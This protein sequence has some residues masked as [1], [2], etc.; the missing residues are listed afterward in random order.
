MDRRK[1]I[2]TNSIACLGLYLSI[3]ELKASTHFINSLSNIELN[4]LFANIN[5][6]ENRKLALLENSIYKYNNLSN[7]QILDS[8]K[9][10]Y[11]LRYGERSNNK[12]KRST[13]KSI[14][15]N[16][17]LNIN[18][19]SKACS[20][21]NEPT[22]RDLMPK[23]LENGYTSV[24]ALGVG[25]VTTGVIAT[26]VVSVPLFL[27][28]IGLTALGVGGATLASSLDEKRKRENEIICANS[29]YTYDS[30]SDSDKIFYQSDEI[31]E[32][33]II[34]FRRS[35]DEILTDNAGKS[36][37]R[38]IVTQAE[39]EGESIQKK[40]FL[41]IYLNNLKKEQELKEQKIKEA[42]SINE[43]R[44]LITE[45]ETDSRENSYKIYLAEVFIGKV[46]G[47]PEGARKFSKVAS[48]INQM[49]GS[50][51]KFIMN[52]PAVSTLAF[53]ANWV[54]AGLVI[55]SVLQ[56]EDDGEA[57]AWK[58]LFKQLQKLTELI[59]EGFDA[60]LK[61]QKAILERLSEIFDLIQNNGIIEQSFL[62]EIKDTLNN[63]EQKLDQVEL[64]L[65]MNKVIESNSQLSTLFGDKK[66]N[67]NKDSY[68]VPFNKYITN[69]VNHGTIFSTTVEALNGYNRDVSSKELFKTA[70]SNISL[71]QQF[72]LI[73]VAHRLS[74]LLSDEVDYSSFEG[75]VANPIEWIRAT[76]LYLQAIFVGKP[77]SNFVKNH[78]N[79][80]KNQGNLIIR[81]SNDYS[82][83][84]FQKKVNDNHLKL[85]EE[86]LNNLVIWVKN[87]AIS[88][89]IKPLLNYY[90]D[91]KSKVKKL[92]RNIFK[93]V[94]N[95]STQRN[96]WN[97]E[98][99]TLR[100]HFSGKSFKIYINEYDGYNGNEPLYTIDYNIFEVL[101]LLKSKGVIDYTKQ[102]IVA[103]NN[104]KTKYTKHYI[105]FNKR[106]LKGLEII[107]FQKKSHIAGRP[108]KGPFDPFIQIDFSAG[109][110]TYN[111]ISPKIN[112]Y[113]WKNK[114]SELLSQSKSKENYFLLKSSYQRNHNSSIQKFRYNFSDLI[115]N[116]LLWE[117]KTVFYEIGESISVK[118]TFLYETYNSSAS[119]LDINGYLLMAIKS[120][121][122][123]KHNTSSNFDYTNGIRYGTSVTSS[124]LNLPQY[125]F[126]NDLLIEL[127]KALTIP[128]AINENNDSG[129]WLN[130][131]TKLN[132][133][134]EDLDPIKN[135]FADYLNPKFKKQHQEIEDSMHNEIDAINFNISYTLVMIETMLKHL[136][137]TN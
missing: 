113:Q 47:D 32:S 118:K 29:I 77:N 133:N 51:S 60:V 81:F 34:P 90:L 96:N 69:Y 62:I 31:E 94:N 92:D 15:Q 27:T 67:L 88:R 103:N 125:C 112:K 109:P 136:E 121:A 36:E 108:H 2:K 12:L 1:F 93:L 132:A 53:S 126:F 58:E 20:Y 35:T 105:K 66:F 82:S 11:R 78:L 123:Y 116:E 54:S 19:L 70:N 114:A 104:Y 97:L 115:A 135:A 111:G 86:V 43:R 38:D 17:D 79:D 102:N 83:Q 124:L 75:K 10:Q 68:R 13:K 22:I 45:I 25:I 50:Y 18:E 100:S 101:N 16:S 30:L 33:I 46:L 89:G 65:Y 85:E 39:N 14:L 106:E 64:D 37:L 40:K 87:D 120:L 110:I 80:F 9:T 5:E 57:N 98:R 130:Q 131:V 72:G 28:G 21:K 99:D 134:R 41:Q 55:M 4:A 71:E 73:S 127:Q 76:Q 119:K 8:F 84:S 63:I 117:I 23:F 61:N 26:S 48:S 6:N 59:I 128:S 56:G 129:I 137:K 74:G 122:D 52:P 107:F 91:Y 7:Q 95:H 44:K 24:G 42:N 49:Y 3:T